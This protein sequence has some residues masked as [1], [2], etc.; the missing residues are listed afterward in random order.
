MIAA[1]KRDETAVAAVEMDISSEVRW[2]RFTVESAIP[3]PLL[4]R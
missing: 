1:A 4:L 2:A 3:P